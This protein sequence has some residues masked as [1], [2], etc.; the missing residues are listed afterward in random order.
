MIKETGTESARPWMLAETNWKAVQETDYDL[1]ILP[2]G[3]TE[4]HNYHLPY[5]TDNYQA[6]HV[7]SE[8]A[9]LAW[10]KGARPIVFP[11]LPFG[12]NTGQ[13]D[14]DL[15]MNIL[16]STQLAILQ[17][18]TD[19]VERA[20]IDKLLILNGHGG[21][22]FKTMIRELSFHFP[23]IFVAWINWYDFADWKAFF[24]DLGDHAGEL[25][26]SCMLHI[27]P[28]FVRPLGEAGAGKV[29]KPV[30]KAMQ[31][32]KVSGQRPWSVVT[33]DTGVGDPS[34]ASSEKGKRYLEACIAS[35]AEFLV[36][37]AGTRVDE[38]YA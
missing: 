1:A 34:R 22:H 35:I 8:A 20:G 23:D 4:A 3:A 11:C 9:R 31:E 16:P 10:E 37:L 14:I 19:V 6:D 32:G 28:Q 38:M 26:T 13:L 27:A 21:N 30:I 18:L 5:A 29:L 2:W 33:E 15:C 7:V 12:V 36:D 25:E 17:D 24:E